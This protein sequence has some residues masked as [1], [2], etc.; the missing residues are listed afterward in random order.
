VP[1]N[2]RPLCL[3]CKVLPRAISLPTTTWNLPIFFSL[4]TLIKQLQ[5]LIFAQ[6]K[7]FKLSSGAPAEMTTISHSGTDIVPKRHQNI[8][9]KPATCQ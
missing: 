8:C 1:R 5:V 3:C 2:S 9:I 7:H 4:W 6:I